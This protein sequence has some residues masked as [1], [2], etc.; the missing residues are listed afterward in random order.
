MNE[1]AELISLA[2]D[3]E[4]EAAT[5]VVSRAYAAGCLRRIAQTL[6]APVPMIIHC[7]MCAGRH[8]DM[9]EFETKPHS[10]H[11]CQHCGFV[12]RPALVATVG[13]QF[14]P[15]FK[16][17]PKYTDFSDV[18]LG[19]DAI[20]KIPWPKQHYQ[21]EPLFSDILALGERPGAKPERIT[22]DLNFNGPPEDPQCYECGSILDRKEGT[23]FWKCGN[24]GL[25]TE[26]DYEKAKNRAAELGFDIDTALQ[27]A[28]E[29]LCP[30][31]HVLM[32]LRLC[33]SHPR[34]TELVC[35]CGFKKEVRHE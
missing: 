8:I 9:G 16:D 20:N 12:W 1:A 35:V 4:N 23:D 10:T 5:T 21:E 15:G 24:C 28:K 14:L 26:K 17:A 18:K 32:E 19:V 3:L 31:C 34:R 11:A 7:P 30:N 27:L 2:E 13:V 6:S 25:D 22:L 33:T 29:N